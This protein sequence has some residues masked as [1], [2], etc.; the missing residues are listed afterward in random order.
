MNIAQFMYIGYISA[1]SQIS[2]DGQYIVLSS[3]HSGA[4]FI[5]SDDSNVCRERV[6][7]PWMF[8]IDKTEL[9]MPLW[10]KSNCINLNF[11]LN[12]INESKIIL[13]MNLYDEKEH[14]TVI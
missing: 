6:W 14:K 10:K 7:E 1:C 11:V 4:I 9:W 5:R 13:I 12:I 3:K 2:F 8:L